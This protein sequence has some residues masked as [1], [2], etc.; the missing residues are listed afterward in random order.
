ME[1][2]GRALFS[3]SGHGAAEKAAEMYQKRCPQAS[4]VRVFAG[5]KGRHFGKDD[6]YC[7]SRDDL[8]FGLSKAYDTKSLIHKGLLS[9]AVGWHVNCISE[10]AKNGFFRV[11]LR[12]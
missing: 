6:N 10:S 12:E 1:T 8:S 7:Q 9:A 11:Q 2:T 4:R 5:L 3:F